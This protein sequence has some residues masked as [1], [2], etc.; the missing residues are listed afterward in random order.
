MFPQSIDLKKTEFF[1]LTI[2]M[3]LRL[4]TH[5]LLQIQSL[6]IIEQ[7]INRTKW[8]IQTKVHRIF[9]DFPGIH[10]FRRYRIRGKLKRLII[11]F[12]PILLAS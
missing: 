7:P 3:I 8:A 6:A 11:F 4:N 12:S 2:L 10:T 9:R 5:L 1:L